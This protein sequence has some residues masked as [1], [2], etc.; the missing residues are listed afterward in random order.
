MN[1]PMPWDLKATS[2]PKTDDPPKPSI[3]ILVKDESK[4]LC[5]GASCGVNEDI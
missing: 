1:E 5:P 2:V 3:R 4:L